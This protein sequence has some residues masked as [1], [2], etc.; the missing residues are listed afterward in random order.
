[1]TDKQKL[2]G[3]GLLLYWLY[4][5]NQTTGTSNVN[6]TWTNP[7][8]GTQTPIVDNSNGGPTFGPSIPPEYPLGGG[9]PQF[10]DDSS[11]GIY[12]DT[13]SGILI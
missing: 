5:R 8:T 4:S 9:S 6:M 2:V 10:P 3:L 13:G 1:M 12:I 7:V 11:S